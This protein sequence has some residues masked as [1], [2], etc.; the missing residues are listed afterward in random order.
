M[1]NSLKSVFLPLLCLC[2]AFSEAAAEEPVI[3]PVDKV[4]FHLSVFSN[5]L[6]S[7]V[8]VT[9][10]AG[11]TIPYHRHEQDL[12]VVVLEAANTQNQIL[13]QPPVDRVARVGAVTFA[14]YTKKPGVHQLINTDAKPY[15]LLGIGIAYPE[16]G[17][18]TPS[19]REEV[20]AYRTVLNNERVR[21]GSVVIEPGQ[22]VSAIGQKAPG[23]R[24]VV[25]GGELIEYEPGKP[26]RPML[27]KTGDFMWQPEGATR[28]LRN[29]GA[30]QIEF[31]EFELK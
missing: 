7:L 19:T 14:A 21:A 22:Q 5:S 2:S 11:R 29:A 12:M 20:P 1:F 13:G 30:V 6:V 23:G 16:P 26:E 18:F 28:E 3:V 8:H 25:K 15:R 10:P 4:A 9:L 31:V 27:L 24:L 17:R